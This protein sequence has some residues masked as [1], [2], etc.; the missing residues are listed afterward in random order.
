MGAQSSST[1]IVFCENGT[2]E[3]RLR[4][5]SICWI[6]HRLTACLSKALDRRHTTFIL[7]SSSSNCALN[8]K[9]LNATRF[10][11]K[12]SGIIPD[13]I[14]VYSGGPGPLRLVLETRRPGVDEAMPARLALSGI[15]NPEM[16]V[17]RTE[18]SDDPHTM[19]MRKS[20]DMYQDLQETATSVPQTWIPN[21]AHILKNS[22]S[23]ECL[24]LAK[25]WFDDC[26]REHPQC[27]KKTT[28]FL[29][30]RVIDVKGDRLRL[31]TP[32]RD[33]MG[34]W[35]ALSHCWGS[36]NTFKTTLET[37]ESH[38]LGI[39]WEELPK[40]FKDAVTVARALEVDYLWIDSL[41]IIQDDG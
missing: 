3:E 34:H 32:R 4:T 25:T 2:E 39:E 41:C 16:T 18:T 11:L 17:L 33:A 23:N 12:K 30:H 14:T 35:I 7:G 36:T 37:L 6:C 13:R 29:P 20:Y 38:H 5:P 1:S 21:A 31:F 8:H 27:R 24:S 28:H 19:Y 26:L 22:Y 9:L 15:Q 10:F 40:T